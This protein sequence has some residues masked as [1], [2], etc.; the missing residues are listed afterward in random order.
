MK[1]IILALVIGCAFLSGY[2]FR[3]LN[4]NQTSQNMKRVTGI[5]GIFFK[6]KDP[7]KMNE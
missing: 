6:C 5:G 7:K 2:A 3:S 4:D 1:K